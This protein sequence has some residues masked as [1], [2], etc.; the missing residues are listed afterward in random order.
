M[1]E[2]VDGFA[3]FT[4]E[5]PCTGYIVYASG[6]QPYSGLPP[7]SVEQAGTYAAACALLWF[8]GSVMRQVLDFSKERSQGNE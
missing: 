5:Q 8:I 2:T 7:L 1:I 4:D 6:E 3:R